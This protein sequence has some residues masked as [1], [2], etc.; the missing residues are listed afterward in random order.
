MLE[1]VGLAL[2][3]EEQILVLVQPP[4]AGPGAFGMCKMLICVRYCSQNQKDGLS[5]GRVWG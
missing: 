1:Q 5:G 4:S 3:A 2:E